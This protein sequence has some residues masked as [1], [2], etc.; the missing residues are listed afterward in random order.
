MDEKTAILSIIRIT[1]DCT[2]N[3]IDLYSITNEEITAAINQILSIPDNGD[4]VVQDLKNK[5]VEALQ[6]MKA[7]DS[8]RNAAAIAGIINKHMGGVAIG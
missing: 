7:H 4:D 5:S 3:I 6:H 8:K 2:D 1:K